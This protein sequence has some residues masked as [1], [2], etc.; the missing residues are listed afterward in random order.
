MKDLLK[1]VLELKAQV[2]VEIIKLAHTKSNNKV[3]FEE[4]V[5]NLTAFRLALK[6][7]ETEEE[8]QLLLLYEDL[9]SSAVRAAE[10]Q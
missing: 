9:T 6:S 8:E 10:L 4:S 7:V 1:K 2:K 3:L 5:K